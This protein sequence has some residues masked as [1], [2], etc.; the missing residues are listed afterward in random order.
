MQTRRDFLMGAASLATMIASRDTALGAQTNTG[1]AW[2][3]GDVAHVLP[4]ANHQRFL[5]KASFARPH[6]APPVL[7]VDRRKIAGRGADT[8]GLFWIFDATGLEPGRR[9]ELQIVDGRGRALCDP[10]PLATFPSPSDN[11]ARLRLLIYSCAGGHDVLPDH[12]P[13]DV[14]T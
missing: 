9:Y 13:T 4:T 8:L 10:W 14:S 12:K 5:I 3:S 7:L 1:A 2:N 6:Q 11:P